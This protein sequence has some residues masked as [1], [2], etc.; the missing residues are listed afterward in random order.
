MVVRQV[1]VLL[2]PSFQ[3]I[4]GD[5]LLLLKSE[6]MMKYL[7][8]KLG[9]ALKL[10][11]HIDKLKQSR[12]WFSAKVAA[13][14]TASAAALLPRELQKPGS[15]FAGYQKSVRFFFTVISCLVVIYHSLAIHQHSPKYQNSSGCTVT[16]LW[17]SIVEAVY[18]PLLL[19]GRIILFW[20]ANSSEPNC[21]NCISSETLST[22]FWVFSDSQRLQIQP[23][24][25]KLLE[26]CFLCFE[27]DVVSKWKTCKF[28]FLYSHALVNQVLFLNKLKWF[29]L[30]SNSV[31]V[32]HK[33][34]KRVLLNV[35]GKTT[36]VQR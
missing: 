12:L 13:T 33:A 32:R 3:E 30:L 25:A 16:Q 34:W 7:G 22:H 9:P 4:D 6:M 26:F 10:S 27:S 29:A 31:L 23:Q 35:W 5:A 2:L 1:R 36:T 19:T 24:E 20:I 11:Y 8:L 14:A 18:S 21:I 15:I 17:F 28:L